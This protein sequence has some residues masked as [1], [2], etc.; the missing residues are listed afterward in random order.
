MLMASIGELRLTLYLYL[1]H[2]F[3]SYMI[4]QVLG[5]NLSYYCQAGLFAG[6]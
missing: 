4:D 5:K 1:S 6:F 2:H 3:Y